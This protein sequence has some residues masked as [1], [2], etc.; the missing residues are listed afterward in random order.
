MKE[1]VP[2][3]YEL[4]GTAKGVPTMY[5]RSKL[6]RY[7]RH[8]VE[9]ERLAPAPAPLKF[10]DGKVE[11]EVDRVL[12]HRRSEARGSTSCN[13]RGPP[14]LPGNGRRICLDVLNS[15]RDT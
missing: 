5:H 15:S 13:G 4:T 11:Y 1:I 7:L 2:D 12:D 6:R 10:M 3:T 14:T 9:G 8:E